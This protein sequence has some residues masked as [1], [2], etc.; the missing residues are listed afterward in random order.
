MIR[1]LRTWAATLL[2]NR[3]F[4]LFMLGTGVSGIGYWFLLVAVGWLV[5]ELGNSTFLLGLANFAQMAPMFFLGLFGG[6]A[7]D[8]FNRRR[9]MLWAQLVVVVGTL[10]LAA[11]ASL[12][13]ISVIAILAC[14]LIFG[15]AN[16]VLWPTWSVFIK[17]LVG[18]ENLRHAVALN[19]ARFNLTRVIGPALAGLL[20]ATVGPAWCL[21]IGAI[22]SLSVVGTILLMKLP[23]W[24]PPPPATES[25]FA[26]VGQ[27][28]A[29]VWRT[30]PVRR[31]LAITGVIGLVA[32]PFQAFLPA[33]ARDSL[34]G[35]AETLGWLTA[36]V[37]VGAMIGALGSGSRLAMARPLWTLVVLAGGVAGGLALLSLSNTLWLALAGLALL[38]I[39]AFA[40]LS[41]ANASV[42]LAV[43]EGLVGRVMG[44]WVVLNAGTQPLGS[45]AEG[46]LA[47]RWG[48][49]PMFA[50]TAAICGAL[51]LWL[52]AEQLRRRPEITVATPPPS[53]GDLQSGDARPQPLA[54][55]AGPGAIRPESTTAASHSSRREPLA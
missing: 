23:P 16:S 52:L 55:P 22:S 46:A 1:S 6:V 50:L 26:S 15:L 20:L 27:A 31:I 33:L 53:A 34:G 17:D 29:Y 42:Q 21:W 24:Q 14:S 13:L 40:F 11:L 51:T 3:N 41:M 37:G 45:L 44:L 7:A 32:L 9:L 43:P 12:G 54:A 10:A 38:G 30:P 35:G 18:P 48:L 8:R 36:A 25:V 39:A 49:N 2:I 47:E 5:L 19:A 28:L 4:A